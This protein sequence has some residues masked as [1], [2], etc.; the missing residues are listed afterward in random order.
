MHLTG[1]GTILE[2]LEAGKPLIVVVND[3]LMGNHQMEVAQ[4]LAK[5]NH[6]R[7]CTPGQ[8]VDTLATF[9]TADVRPF[10]KASPARFHATLDTLMGFAEARPKP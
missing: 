4:Q 7:F 2:V 9:D 5:D 8:L 1:A 10:P 3:T 6:L